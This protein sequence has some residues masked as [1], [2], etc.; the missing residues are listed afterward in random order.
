MRAVLLLVTPVAFA[1]AYLLLAWTMG[2][3]DLAIDAW[4]V[5]SLSF[6]ASTAGMLVGV[7]RIESHPPSTYGLAVILGLLLGLSWRTILLLVGWA[8]T[9]LGVVLLTVGAFGAFTGMIIV[10]R[11]DSTLPSRAL[12]TSIASTAM[13]LIGTAISRLI[14]PGV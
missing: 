8:A 12:A 13:A 10:M 7:S 4:V 6:F 3:R 9:A 11:Q 1:S 14:V 2:T 5:I